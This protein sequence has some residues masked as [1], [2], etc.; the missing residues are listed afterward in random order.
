MY[1]PIVHLQ[2]SSGSQKMVH[3]QRGRCRFCGADG[4]GSSR[5]K[6]H[7]VPEALGNR[8]IFSADECYACNQKF[9]LYEDAL[10]AA[11]GPILTLGGTAGKRGKA[12][13]TGRSAGNSVL[14]HTRLDGQRQLRI[15]SQ[16]VEDYR[17]RVTLD[18][19]WIVTRMPLPLTPF[20]P[21]LA[22]KALV[23]MALTLVPVTDLEHYGG[24]QPFLKD[25]NAMA[26]EGRA[27][28]GLSFGSIGNAP[29]MVVA[30]LLQRV[31][32]ALLIPKFIF[33]LCV[34]SVCLQ[35]FLTAD[36]LSHTGV[37]RGTPTLQFTVVLGKPGAED[38]RIA[39]NNLRV[40]DWSSAA[41]EP[42]PLKEIVL[43]FNQ[44]TTQAEFH[45]VWR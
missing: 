6:A 24:L 41:P 10:V 12:R 8:W 5:K 37:M 31:D 11:V 9:S 16:N 42:Q 38:L 40:L 30:S 18:G 4:A 44:G 22:Y 3:G 17:E 25:R 1:R 14:T 13:Q 36:S 26:P 32:N 21:L 28:V 20:T 39:Y 23:K 34:G 29:P 35:L 2:A 19:D 27:T 33:I 43:R 7:L 15:I 45:P